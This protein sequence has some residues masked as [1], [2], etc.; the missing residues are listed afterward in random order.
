MTKTKIKTYIFW[1]QKGDN[2]LTFTEFKAAHINEVR[3]WAKSNGVKI[4][5]RIKLK[6]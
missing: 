2:I 5:G 6:K 3:Q 1:S 4:D